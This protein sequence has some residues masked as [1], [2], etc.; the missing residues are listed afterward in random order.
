MKIESEKGGRGEDCQTAVNNGLESEGSQGRESKAS[1]EQPPVMCTTLQTLDC[2]GLP[3]S[4]WVATCLW[5]LF[6]FL[7]RNLARA[8]LS[9]LPM[10]TSRDSQ[11]SAS[12][13]MK[14]TNRMIKT[15]SE[16]RNFQNR[17]WVVL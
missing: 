4:L 14:I 8:T 1:G 3:G 2:L 9:L 17:T 16:C 10:L 7:S 13:E 5:L 15:A 11:L 6:G 12:Q